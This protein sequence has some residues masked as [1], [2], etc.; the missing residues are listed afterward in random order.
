MKLIFS[1]TIF[2]CLYIIVRG[3]SEVYSLAYNPDNLLID[4]NI[5][6][7]YAIKFNGEEYRHDTYES[8]S[9]ALPINPRW[10]SI[11][12][13]SGLLF[14]S[15]FCDGTS[16]VLK[17]RYQSFE[18]VF[19]GADDQFWNYN[20]SWKNKYKDGLPPDPRFFGSKSLFVWT[21]DGYHMMRMMRNVTMIT[22]VTIP[23]SINHR[24]TFK[25]YLLEGIIYYI[26]YTAGFNMAYDV[27]FK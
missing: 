9:E 18:R 20:I 26:S 10:K 25:S 13:S 24:K 21:T 2:L 27:V 4:E 22:A 17:I 8:T 16:E 12:F 7:N 3:Q 1:I 23:I 5:N 6:P 15:G 19:P 14:I 11:A